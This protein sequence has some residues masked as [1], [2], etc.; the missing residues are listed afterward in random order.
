MNS[1]ITNDLEG[2]FKLSKFNSLYMNIM[3]ISSMHLQINRKLWYD[4]QIW[5]EGL[6][7]SQAYCTDERQMHGYYSSNI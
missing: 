6:L 4:Y 1:G 2:H 3:Y 7:K 5:T